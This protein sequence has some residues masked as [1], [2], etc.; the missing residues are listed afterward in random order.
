MES[1]FQDHIADIVQYISLP[2]EIVGFVMVIIEIYKDNEYQKIENAIDNVPSFMSAA[3]NAYASF[4]MGPEGRNSGSN[5]FVIIFVVFVAWAIWVIWESN[6]AE[7]VTTDFVS[8]LLTSFY[9]GFLTIFVGP[10]VLY[11]IPTVIVRLLNY[12]TGGRALG[13][14]GLILAGLGLLGELYQVITMTWFS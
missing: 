3:S 8:L 5:L 9:V 6:S 13:T 7:Q 2:L 1:I 14:I 12:I 11:A 10:F 4:L